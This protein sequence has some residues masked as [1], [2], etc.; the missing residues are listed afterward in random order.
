MSSSQQS[1][2]ISEIKLANDQLKTD[3]GEQEYNK[4]MNTKPL[5]TISSS[6]DEGLKLTSWLYGFSSGKEEELYLDL[7]LPFIN[8][9]LLY[10][11]EDAKFID[12]ENG[13]KVGYFLT[14]ELPSTTEG[15]DLTF[16][17]FFIEPTKDLT[18]EELK[19]L[20][21]GLKLGL[22]GIYEDLDFESGKFAL[23]IN[24]SDYT[25]KQ[26]VVSR[27]LIQATIVLE[28]GLLTQDKN[29]LMIKDESINLMQVD[30]NY[31]VE[32]MDK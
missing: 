23:K 7:G 15:K 11:M 18:Y 30:A 27:S 32:I 19:P 28:S 21:K 17:N 8:E 3:S 5:Y 20:L 26:S 22:N 16:V 29:T 4:Y 2:L 24:T 25:D 31:R 13:I 10:A 12:L 14:T 6:L 9:N 1:F